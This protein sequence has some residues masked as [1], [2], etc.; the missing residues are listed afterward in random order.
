MSFLYLDTEQICRPDQYHEHLSRW[1][2][3]G[4]FFRVV[5]L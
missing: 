4:G 3:T 5:F 1:S 2:M